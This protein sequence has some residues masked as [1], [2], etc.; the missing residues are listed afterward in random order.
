MTGWQIAALILVVLILSFVTGRFTAPESIVRSDTVEV[1]KVDT[2]QIQKI[3]YRN[4]PAKHETVYVKPDTSFSW[5]DDN[6]PIAVI[7]SVDTVFSSHNDSLRVEYIEPDA[8]FNLAFRPGPR[9]VQTVDTI[10]YVPKPYP[11]ETVSMPWVVG[12]VAIG[13]GLGVLFAK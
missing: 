6:R 4:L 1:V 9:L 10:I 13:I 8:V 2:F 3:V 7:H 5:G 12:S 11:V